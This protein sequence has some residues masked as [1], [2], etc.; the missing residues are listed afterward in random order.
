MYGQP[1]DTESESKKT[2][3]A[4]P[5]LFSVQLYWFGIQARA[6]ATA[7][8]GNWTGEGNTKSRDSGANTTTHNKLLHRRWCIE[9][10]YISGR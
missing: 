4:D 10:H 3:E 6:G 9:F 2:R 1:R 8:D 5:A 7:V